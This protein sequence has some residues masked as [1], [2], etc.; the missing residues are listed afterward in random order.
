MDL[1]T[2]ELAQQ[3]CMKRYK[4]QK[5]AAKD[6]QKALQL[7]V[8]ERRALNYGT[9]IETQQKITQNAF[10]TKNA[11]S[12]IRTVLKKNTRQAITY[13]KFTD[14]YDLI[15]HCFDREEINDAC[16]QED[17]QWYSQSHTT[18]FLVT[19]LLEEFGFFGNQE[20]IQAVLDGT[21]QCPEGVDI[22][23]QKCIHELRK[24]PSIPA[25]GTID[26]TA[27]TDEHIQGWNKM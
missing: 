7:K 16:I 25:L 10:R 23:T 27:S 13:V 1:E 17:R 19:P 12:R 21:Y 20:Q 4:L 15:I 11:F 18:P 6:L 3:A 9:S 26:G 14:E 8:K 2:A 24:P 5:A 22:Y